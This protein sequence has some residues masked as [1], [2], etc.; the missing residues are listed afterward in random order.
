MQPERHFSTDPDT[1]I[2]FGKVLALIALALAIGIIG[3][4]VAAARMA[5]G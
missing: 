4:I 5:M 2:D 3:N 1:R